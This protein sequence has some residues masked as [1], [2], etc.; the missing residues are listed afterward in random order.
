V[1]AAIEITTEALDEQELARR[2][3]A[4][5]SEQ[6]GEPVQVDG[7]ELLTGG[8]AREMWAFE[9]RTP[10]GSRHY[11][12]RKNPPGGG[13]QAI[14]FQLDRRKEFMAMQLAHAARVPVARVDWLIEDPT[15]FGE[16][17]FIMERLF[18]ETIPR[19][20]L[21]EPQFARAREAAT[22][23]LGQALARIHRIDYSS[24]ELP[25]IP[26]GEHPAVQQLQ[27]YREYLDELDDPRP[28]W[29]I[30]MR[31]LWDNLPG[32]WDL[33][34]VHSDFR[35]GNLMFDE[36]GL[37]AVLDWEI[38][39]EGDPMEDIGWLCVPSWRY[40]NFDKPIGGFGERA[41]FYDGYESVAGFRPDPPAVHFWEVLGTLK[42]GI[43]C[44]SNQVKKTKRSGIAG[45]VMASPGRKLE[46]LAQARRACEMELDLLQLLGER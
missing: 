10:S 12:L 29:E 16:A 17:G 9:A 19:R 3:A 39:H 21:R 30:G 44:S 18:G 35:N 8:N 37:L 42:W 15:V 6:L 24:L 34:L 45:G 38:V 20:F 46:G 31:W 36:Q 7:V 26:E 32:R 11:V 33:T 14:R 22:F 27:E 43:L 5:V 1:A 25:R 13:P 41:E 28:V 40:G 4:F 23:Q 2:L